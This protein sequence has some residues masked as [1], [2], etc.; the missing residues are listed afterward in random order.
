MS[1]FFYGNNV[2]FHTACYFF[3]LFKEDKPFYVMDTMYHF[4]FIRQLC[5][6]MSHLDLNYKP[7]YKR[8]MWINGKC[9]NQLETALPE[10]PEIR[11]GL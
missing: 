7:Q 3:N 11:L 1:A 5:K 6:Y 2:P 8:V 9:L 10:V 4:Y